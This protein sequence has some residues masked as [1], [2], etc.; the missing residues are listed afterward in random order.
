MRIW[1]QVAWLASAM[2][3]KS[4]RAATA[5]RRWASLPAIRESWLGERRCFIRDHRQGRPGRLAALQALQGVIDVAVQERK[6]GVKQV[7]FR[8][9]DQTP[10]NIERLQR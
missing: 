6:P 9:V 10:L 7:E 3:S 5:S 8:Q 4:P 1:C 2:R